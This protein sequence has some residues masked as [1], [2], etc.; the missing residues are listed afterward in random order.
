MTCNSF[1]YTITN[2]A[3]IIH[4]S[5]NFKKVLSIKLTFTCSSKVI[6][7]RDMKRIKKNYYYYG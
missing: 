1:K 7:Y 2:Y 4:N 5:T 6:A 3:L